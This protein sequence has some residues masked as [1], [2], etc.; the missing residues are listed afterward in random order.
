MR[1]TTLV[2][3]LAFTMGASAKA[4]PNAPTF[5]VNSMDDVV[6]A[7][8][9]NDGICATAYNSG[10]PNGVCTLRAAIMKTNHYPGGGVTINIPAILGRT[11]V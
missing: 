10:V 9:L 8:P 1:V 5:T 7:A 2:L 4:A 6:A 3:A 11:C